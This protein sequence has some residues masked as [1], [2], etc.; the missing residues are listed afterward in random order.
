MKSINILP[1]DILLEV[2]EFCMDEIHIAISGTESWQSLLHVCRRWR[3]VVFRSSRC[4]NLRLRCTAKTPVRDTLDIWPPFPLVVDDIAGPTED[5]DNVFAALERRDRV[6]RIRLR[7]ANGSSLEKVLAAMQEP[8]PELTFLQLSSNEEPVPIVPDSFLGRSAPRLRFLVLDGIP[9]PGLPKLLLSATYLVYLHLY[10]I[11]HSGYIS[12]DAMVTALTA[13]TSLQILQL[14]FRS[15]RSHPDQ[16]SRHPPPPTRTVLP[17]LTGIRFQG[18]CEYLD[19]LVA[20]IDSPQLN[21]LDITLFNDVVFDAPQFI[22][23]ISRTPTLKLVEDAHVVFGHGKAIINSSPRYES[24]YEVGISCRE[25]DWQVSS[26]EQ[27][28]ASHF[29]PLSTL[30]GLYIYERL[31]GGQPDWRDNIENTLW[32]DLLH[33]FTTVKNLYL[34]KEFAPRIVAALQELVGDRT[35]EVLPTLQN[36]FLEEVEPG[37]CVREDIERIVSARQLSGHTL[38]VSYWERDPTRERDL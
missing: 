1:D 15:P 34:S 4:L 10:N 21:I 31:H 17:S 38:A 14:E 26:L 13:L 7:E 29:P 24:R 28:C 6:D 5:M 30:E 2:F 36:I 25:L 9:F 8:F 37:G 32:L 18:V 20:R 33:R 19:D 23:F 11:P 22:Q 3:C 35:T 12:P 16:A 27:L